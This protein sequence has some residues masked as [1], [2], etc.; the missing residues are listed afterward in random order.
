MGDQEDRAR[1]VRS[2]DESQQPVNAEDCLAGG[3]HMGA[4]TR[5]IDWSKTT[6]GPLESWSPTL[7]MMVRLILWNRLQMLL[8]WGPQFVQIYNDA[9]WPALGTKHPRSMG[10]P[11]SECWSEIW[12]IIGPLIEAPFRGGQA[13][14][15]EDI[16]LEINR[17]GFMEETHWTIAYSPVLDETAPGGIGGVIGTVNEITEKI[18]GERRVLLLRDLGARSSEAKTA[19][20]ACAIAAET[21]NQHREDVPFALLYLVSE[22]RKTAHLAGAAGLDMGQPESP[23]DVDLQTGAT[24]EHVWPLPEALSQEQVQFVEALGSRLSHVPPGPWSDPPRSAVVCP[25]RSNIAHQ[26]AGLLVLGISSRLTFDDRY[27]CFC[28]LV[29]GQIANAIANARAYEE[30][31][32]RAE[33]LAEIDR[34]KTQFFSNVSHEFRTPLTLMLGPLEEM[35]SRGNGE[36]TIPSHELEL[37]HRNCLRLLKLVNALLDFSRIEAGRA[38]ASYEPVDLPTFTA[39]LASVF[40]AAIEKAGL[41]LNID[42]PGL[43]EPVYVDR[44]MWEKIVLNLLSNAFKFTFEGEVTVAVKKLNQH[45]ELSVADTGIGIAEDELPRVFER[46]HRIEGARGRT[47]E[48]SGIGLALVQELAKLHGGRVNV[49]STYGKGTQFTV[50]IP[51]GRAHLPARRVEPG[52]V[53]HT[54]GVNAYVREALRWLPDTS[55]AAP[56]EPAAAQASELGQRRRILFADDNADLRQYVYRLLSADYEVELVRDGE[57]ALAAALRTMPDLVLSDVMM[58]RLDGFGLLKALRDHPATSNIPVI[59]L[60]ARAGQESR[61]DGFSA[62]ATD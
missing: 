13:T 29:S 9:F 49:A 14:W 16:F 54:V 19:E 42:C 27:R 35:L 51:M 55:I 7:R 8:W 50:S 43:D 62:G 40:R 1:A 47:F 56:S 25:V 21:M 2:S 36:V 20:E 58:P 3:G 32:K 60:S 30:E 37:V 11:A 15:M 57:A 61:V 46:F 22:D 44:A 34:A 33:A 38:Q 6:I 10:Q 4:L 5:S 41:R 12:H 39:E 48:G 26:L 28:D 24:N 52:R 17:K 18:V 31:R 23:M 53:S 59:L 45:V